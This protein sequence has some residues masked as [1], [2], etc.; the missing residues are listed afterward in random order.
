LTLP[1]A[2]YTHADGTIILTF[3]GCNSGTVEY[4][5]PS[6]GRSGVVP[7]QRI[8]GDNIEQCENSGSY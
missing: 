4:D 3:T 2:E 6:I 8:V 7:I 5:I 1:V